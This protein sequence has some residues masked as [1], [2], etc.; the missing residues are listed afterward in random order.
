MFPLRRA[1]ETFRSS[2]SDF[3]GG[4]MGISKHLRRAERAERPGEDARREELCGEARE[5]EER[6]L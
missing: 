6:R 4:S 2:L 3:I 5:A 1:D